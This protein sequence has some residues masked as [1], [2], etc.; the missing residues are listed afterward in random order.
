MPWK[1]SAKGKKLTTAKQRTKRM[2]KLT[3]AKD[4]PQYAD[5]LNSQRFWEAKSTFGRN[6]TFETPEDLAKACTQYF[7]WVEEHP[8]YEFK[9]VGTHFGEAIIENIPKKRP[10]TQVS[11]CLFLDISQVSWL[12]Y[13]KK[14]PDFL[15]VVDMAMDI[16]KEQ[17]FSGAAAG[18]F[19]TNIICRDLG[20][21]DKKDVTSDGK[22]IQGNTTVINKIDL[23]GLSTLELKSL[24]GLATKLFES[25]KEVTEFEE[26]HRN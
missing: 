16:I 12:N 17:K 14:S 15:R 25:N 24:E 1:S 4:N 5:L 23:S 20:L 13:R 3:G 7:I 10:M 21:I 18:F 2:N 22:A 19:N 26:E 6:P 8:F 9:V 11:L